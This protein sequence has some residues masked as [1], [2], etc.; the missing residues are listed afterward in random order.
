[1]NGGA[2]L[3]TAETDAG[4]R[5]VFS[6][7]LDEGLHRIW[8]R[9][10]APVEGAIAGVAPLL[11]EESIWYLLLKVDPTLP[12][13][14]LSLTFTDSQGRTLRP[15]TLGYSFG[16]TQTEMM[17]RSG[18]TYSVGI[19]R[20][21]ADPN[22]ATQIIFTD[23]IISNLLDEGGNG[24]YTGSFT[25]AP[26]VV[27][28]TPVADS[29]LHFVV[30]T[31]GAVQRYALPVQPLTPATVRDA[32][33]GQPLANASVTARSIA[34]LAQ[35]EP[36]VT[37]PDGA[38]SFDAPAGIYQLE[39][40]RDGYQPYRTGRLNVDSGL[41]AQD[42]SLTP[43]APEPTTHT[44]YADDRGFTPPLLRVEPGS[45]VEWLNLGLDEVAVGGDGWE[46]GALATGGSYKRKLDAEGTFEYRNSNQGTRGAI[47]VA[48]EEHELPQVSGAVFLPLVTR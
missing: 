2:L 34:S 44:I 1:M 47:I 33:T 13:D 25:F 20:C 15:V 6:A 43:A 41:L 39:V 22:Q 38:Y 12:I 37:G 9:Y 14:P 30:T 19:D 18:E 4:G 46:S 8:A 35:L 7:D 17:L 16:L 23:M 29:E 5:F 40:V 3:G 31:G 45:V 28:A 36:Q 11:S 21:G 42:V 10:P 27:S 24:R 48:V 32:Q 26:T